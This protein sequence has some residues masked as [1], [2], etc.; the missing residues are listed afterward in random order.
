M[1]QDPKLAGCS[2]D[3]TPRLGNDS[4]GFGRHRE[5]SFAASLLAITAEH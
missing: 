1:T 4:G 5:R 2:L 3:A